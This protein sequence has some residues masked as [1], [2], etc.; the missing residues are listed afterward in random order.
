MKYFR[1]LPYKKVLEWIKFQ[2]DI[3]IYFK[4]IDRYKVLFFIF[5]MFLP[6]LHLMPISF[7]RS[8]PSGYSELQA[9]GEYFLSYSEIQWLYFQKMK[10]TLTN[11]SEVKNEHSAGKITETAN[12][13]RYLYFIKM[14]Q[15]ERY[16]EAEK[17]MVDNIQNP[18]NTL[19]LMLLY[20][21]LDRKKEAYMILEGWLE[22]TDHFRVYRLADLFYHKKMTRALEF[23]AHYELHN[24]HE[25]NSDIKSEN[26]ES[27]DKG[28][29][30]NKN[31]NKM[32]V[33]FFQQYAATLAGLSQ[34]D[35]SES[36]VRM[37]MLADQKEFAMKNTLI[38]YWYLENDLADALWAQSADGFDVTTASRVP[39]AALSAASGHGTEEEKFFTGFP[40]F[41]KKNEKKENLPADIYSR[42]VLY[43]IKKERLKEAA[44]FIQSYLVSDNADNKR[45]HEKLV[46]VLLKKQKELDEKK[47]NL[48]IL[49]KPAASDA[50]Q[51]GNLSGEELAP[52]ELHGNVE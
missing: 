33:T 24:D 4:Q 6:F 12:K 37:Q 42:Y 2:K 30:A 18:T 52:V 36:K 13:E 32:K 11:E 40:G 7:L 31:E 22:S 41:I 48:K 50:L 44:D 9:G 21:Y 15:K 49:V 25:N 14:V 51:P 8:L 3:I 38:L 29:A 19:D 39:S 45:Y 27:K 17:A 5:F 46:E 23:L 20:L 10:L 28:N 34:G 1:V 47:S 16:A 35:I 43:L 26:V